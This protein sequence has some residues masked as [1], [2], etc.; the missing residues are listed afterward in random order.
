MTTLD[1]N[2]SIQVGITL[3]LGALGGTI[4]FYAGFPAPF[5][6]GSAI[7]VTLA[8]LL[9]LTL[10]IPNLLRNACFVAIGLSMGSGVTPQVLETI[11]LW[12]MAFGILTL[13]L[14]GTFFGCRWMLGRYWHYDVRSATLAAT[15][16]HLSFVLGLSSQNN[17]DI[18]SISIVQSIRVMVLT[19]VVPFA[20]TALGL[21]SG[22][23]AMAPPQMALSALLWLAPVAA[24]IGWGMNRFRLPAA[25]LLG[26]MM[27]STLTHATGV[28]IGQIPPWLTMIAFTIM[29]SLIGTRFSNVTWHQLKNA[30]G[31][32]LAAVL[33]ASGMAV[34]AGTI[35]SW[36]LGLPLPQLLIAFAPGGLEAMAAMAVIMQVDTAFVAAQHIFR[37]FVL[38]FLAPAVLLWEDRK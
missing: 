35:G 24:L 10:R 12:P 27:V 3:S 38:T 6:T 25:Y 30:A 15:P 23:H 20:V 5:L 1:D 16:G 4:A 29:G 19:V 11:G 13:S 32:G 2:K 9:G 7:L 8:C 31:A 14:L 18:A 26:G 33:V 36:W 17:V 28:V 37:L 22:V 34:L 21:N